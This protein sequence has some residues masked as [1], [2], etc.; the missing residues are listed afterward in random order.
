MTPPPARLSASSWPSSVQPPRC[1]W[2]SSSVATAWSWL[3]A[4]N[5]V[6]VGSV[7]ALCVLWTSWGRAP[8][9]ARPRESSRLVSPI[10]LEECGGLPSPATKS[11][12]PRIL[13]ILASHSSNILQES[14][15][16]FQKFQRYLEAPSNLDALRW[17]SANA[18]KRPPLPAAGT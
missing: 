4:H 18:G 2:T 6:V 13:S 8:H 15:G 14:K 12:H 16:C 10:T 11:Y 7:A 1:S 5:S 17:D 3:V 9:F